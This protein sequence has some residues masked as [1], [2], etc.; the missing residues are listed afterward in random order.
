MHTNY[1]LSLNW[2]QL[3]HL[4][5]A[6]MMHC[7]TKATPIQFIND[8]KLKSCKMGL[9]NHTWP[10]SHHITLLV[11]NAFGVDTQTDTHTDA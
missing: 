1:F 9:T 8:N 5:L 11:I 6:C 10:I 7:V 3:Q 2:C 4:C